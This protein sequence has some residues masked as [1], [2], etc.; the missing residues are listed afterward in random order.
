MKTNFA[1]VLQPYW[2]WLAQVR[3]HRQSGPN[4]SLWRLS[5]NFHGSEWQ[6]GFDGDHYND[7]LACYLDN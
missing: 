2:H 3:M 4:M 7:T 6:S 5:D 1:Y